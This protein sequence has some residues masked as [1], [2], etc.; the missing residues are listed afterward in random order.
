MSRLEDIQKQLYT[1]QKPT[2]PP[3]ENTQSTKEP[4]IE[5]PKISGDLEPSSFVW[6]R[7][8]IG[9]GIFVLLSII[10]GIFIFFR[11]FYAFRKDRVEIKI[12][13][14]E[15]IVAGETAS[16]KVEIINKNE[17]EIR[18]GEL[19]FQYP[20]FSKPIL[21]AGESS[22]F[23]QSTGKQTV[24]VSDLASGA[25]FEREFKAVIFGGENFEKKAQAIFKFKPSSGNISFESIAT[26]SL[27]ISSM[28]FDFSFG[29]MEETV[30]GEEIEAVLHVKNNSESKFEDLRIRMEYPSGFEVKSSSEKLYEF[31][32]IWRVDEIQQNES[33]DLTIIGEISGLAGERKFFRAFLEGLEGQNWR[34]YKETSSELKLISPPMVLYLNTEPPSEYLTGGQDATYKIVWQNNLDIPLSNLTLKVKFEGDAFD[35]S[36]ADF[37]GGSFDQQTKTVTWNQNNLPKLFGIQPRET[38]ELG[39]ELK[40]KSGM[41]TGSTAG[42]VATIDSTTKPEGLSISEISSSQN[43]VLPV[44]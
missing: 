17:T 43:L 41:P 2:L 35:F 23:K 4:P 21:K 22:E 18:D 29:I 27:K 42:V 6:K 31:K 13:G 32:N 24:I 19:V 20:D 12:S 34:V 38:G 7:I 14:P 33:K 37:A 28:P 39:I 40:I 36:S 9:F 5:P 25:V 44:R 15:E 16:W 1:P 26:K 8:W 11:G 10:V 30:S 3:V